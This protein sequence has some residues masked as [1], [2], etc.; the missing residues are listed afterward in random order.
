MAVFG[1]F[2]LGF[3]LQRGGEKPL[4]VSAGRFTAN[5]SNAVKNPANSASPVGANKTSA[6][7]AQTAN[8]QTGAS[9]PNPAVKPPL[10]P[11][12]PVSVESAVYF[13]G[14][15]TKKGAPCSRRVR[16]GGRCW[17]HKGQATLLPDEKLLAGQ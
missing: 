12:A 15:A 1:F 14:A 9:P 8:T 3:Y 16:G 17:Q 2:G 5:Q 13:C 10:R 7:I 4:N 11:P 6:P